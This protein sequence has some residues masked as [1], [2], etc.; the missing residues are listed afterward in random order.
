MCQRCQLPSSPGGWEKHVAGNKQ[1]VVSQAV[2]PKS[3]DNRDQ[4][5]EIQ[6]V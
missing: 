4:E 5:K 1:E 6:N 2:V 3:V